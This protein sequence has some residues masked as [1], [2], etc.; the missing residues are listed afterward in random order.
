MISEFEISCLLLAFCGVVAGIG[1]VLTRSS[2]LPLSIHAFHNAA[3]T[4]T[5]KGVSLTLFTKYNDQFRDF[6][7]LV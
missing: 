1:L 2:S 6:G 3:V 7:I 5:V 4:L